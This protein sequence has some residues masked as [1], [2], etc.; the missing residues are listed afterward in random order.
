MKAIGGLKPKST[1]ERKM[2][3]KNTTT[4][5]GFCKEEIITRRRLTPDLRS[6]ARNINLT[7]HYQKV[8]GL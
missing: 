7:R 6:N 8:D 1:Y 4:K 3:M 2:T 5:K